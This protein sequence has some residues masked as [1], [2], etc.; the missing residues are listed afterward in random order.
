MANKD[1]RLRDILLKAGLKGQLKPVGS[2][3]EAH[4]ILITDK[5][6]LTHLVFVGKDEYKQALEDDQTYTEEKMVYFL[7]S[8]NPRNRWSRERRLLTNKFGMT[9]TVL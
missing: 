2:L 6:R 3:E 5:Q 1:K 9:K 8:V 4:I 7:V